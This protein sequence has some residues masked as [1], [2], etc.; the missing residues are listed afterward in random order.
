M[1]KNIPSL[2]EQRQNDFMIWFQIE[3]QN[4]SACAPQLTEYLCTTSIPQVGVH[5]YTMLNWQKLK[6]V[7]MLWDTLRN[8]WSRNALMLRRDYLSLSLFF[9]YTWWWWIAGQLGN[10]EREW[11]S[12]AQQGIR[13]ERGRAPNMWVRF[14]ESMTKL[15]SKPN[16]WMCTQS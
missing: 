8:P 14:G 5:H 9:S 11:G 3:S 15:W 13:P 2:V 7:R 4:H 6:M 16:N 1:Y 12:K 10:N